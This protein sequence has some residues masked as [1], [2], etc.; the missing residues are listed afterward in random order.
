M[1]LRRKPRRA[2]ASRTAAVYVCRDGRGRVVA[3]R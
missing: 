3:S 1:R 2:E